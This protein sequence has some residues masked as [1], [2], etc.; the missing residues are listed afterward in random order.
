MLG[1]TL[2]TEELDIYQDLEKVARDAINKYGIRVQLLKLIEE[3]NEFSA[4]LLHNVIIPDLR[5]NRTMDIKHNLLKDEVIDEI[6]DLVVV[7]SEFDMIVSQ[8]A[9]DPN[10]AKEYESKLINRVKFK[11][12]RLRTK[13][14]KT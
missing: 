3:L 12:N 6:A 10:F 8:F 5:Y 9:A 13:I 4:A 1:D 2:T 7:F 11:I 14:N